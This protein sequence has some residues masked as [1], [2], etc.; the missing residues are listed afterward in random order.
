MRKEIITYSSITY[1]RKDLTT[2]IFLSSVS[3]IVTSGEMNRAK[4]KEF[5]GRSNN[6]MVSSPM[7]GGCWRWWQHGERGL[8]T[9]W[10]SPLVRLDGNWQWWRRVKEFAIELFSMVV[11]SVTSRPNKKRKKMGE[12]ERAEAARYLIVHHRRLVYGG[13]RERE[14]WSCKGRVKGDGVWMAGCPPVM[15]MVEV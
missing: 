15:V 6:C 13:E 7:E 4:M 8:K 5:I 11:S 12:G 3:P 9:S 1:F 14:R 10:R 2:T